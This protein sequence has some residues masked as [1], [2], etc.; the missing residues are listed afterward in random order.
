MERINEL[1]QGA[2]KRR[3]A[4]RTNAGKRRKAARR[5]QVPESVGKRLKAEREALQSRRKVLENA[6]KRKGT[7]RKA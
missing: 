5:W 4:E 1:L 7:P 2:G 6:G 3:K